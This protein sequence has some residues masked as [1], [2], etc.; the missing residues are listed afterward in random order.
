MEITRA[1]IL[2]LKLLKSYLERLSL[3]R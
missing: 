2:K 1:V 3:C